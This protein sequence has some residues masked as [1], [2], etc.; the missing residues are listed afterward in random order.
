MFELLDEQ[1]FLGLSVS[2]IDGVMG[3]VHLR[4]QRDHHI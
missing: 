3:F 1:L 2:L 4:L